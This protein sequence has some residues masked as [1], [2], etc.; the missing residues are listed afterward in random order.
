MQAFTIV[1]LIIISFLLL[2][3]VILLYLIQKNPI[4]RKRNSF[5]KRYFELKFELRVLEAVAAILLFVGTFLGVSSLNEIKEDYKSDLEE[6]IRILRTTTGDLEKKVSN[7]AEALDSLKSEEGQSIENLSDVK[8]EFGIINNKVTRTQEAL[9]Y[10]TRIYVA[11]NLTFKTDKNEEKRAQKYWFKDLRTIYGEKLPV[12]KTAPLVLTQVKKGGVG[13]ITVD[14]TKD[15]V[16]LRLSQ[17]SLMLY[18]AQLSDH[19][20]DMWIAEPN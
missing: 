8:R 1:L 9:K 12:F 18:D 13:L 6:E 7:Y 15:F 14:I 20:F 10:S 16:E 3:D 5:D 19:N 17:E 11:N 4:T 2:L